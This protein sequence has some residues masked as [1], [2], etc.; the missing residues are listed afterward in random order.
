MATIASTSSSTG[1]RSTREPTAITSRGNILHR[2]RASSRARKPYNLAAMGFR[3]HGP[4]QAG[5]QVQLTDPK[6]R[7][8]TI[9]LEARQGVPHPQGRPPARRADRAARGLVVR[10]TGGT[11]PTWRCRR[12]S[13]T[14]SC[15]CRAARPSSTPRTRGRS[16]PWPTSSPAP[17]SSRRGSAPARSRASCCA[18]SVTEGHAHSYER[19]EDFAEIARRTSSASSAAEPAW[20]L[21]V[22]DLQDDLPDTDVDRVILDMLAPWECLDAVAKALVPGGHLLLCRHHHPAVPDRRGDPRARQLHRAA[23]VGDDGPR[24]ARRG[25]RRPPRPP[26]D[27]AHRLPRHRPPPGRRRHPAAAPATTEEPPKL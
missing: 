21:T 8:H 2:Y 5:D 19:R 26:D 15:R 22:G 11:S 1:G 24:L 16:S 27:R 9:T 13:R 25:P 23:A 4:F 12:C 14:T 7:H 18:P 17:G 6:G 3:R 20:Q 10:S